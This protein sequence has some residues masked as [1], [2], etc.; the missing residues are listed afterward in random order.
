[1]MLLQQWLL[2]ASAS[3][4]DS[5]QAFVVDTS[6]VAV[7]GIP[8]LVASLAIPSSIVVGDILA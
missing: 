6:S 5:E 2:L 7:V 8:A 3:S 1:M 4:M